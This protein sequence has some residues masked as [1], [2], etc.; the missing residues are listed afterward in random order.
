MALGLA[1]FDFR[2]TELQQ[3]ECGLGCQLPCFRD[4]NALSALADLASKCTAVHLGGP[5]SH[6]NA[7]QPQRVLPATPVSEEF[8]N[9]NM[10]AKRM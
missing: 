2:T 6:A 1:E 8:S 4:A 7:L 9:T 10:S 3:R 5:D